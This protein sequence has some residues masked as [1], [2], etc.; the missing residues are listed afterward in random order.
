MRIHT[1][2]LFYTLAKWLGGFCLVA[3]PADHQLGR[4][5][6][7]FRSGSRKWRDASERAA[8]AVGEPDHGLAGCTR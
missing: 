2:E 1:A 6:C 4:A 5:D 8:A 3:V 7:G